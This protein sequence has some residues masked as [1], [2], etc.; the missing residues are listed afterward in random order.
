M[1]NHAMYDRAR[2]MICKGNH[3]IRAL[4]AV[5]EVTKT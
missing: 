4:Y 5:S 1:G 2:C 3:E